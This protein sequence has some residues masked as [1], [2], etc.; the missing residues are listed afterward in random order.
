MK[1]DS[2]ISVVIAG[3][4]FCGLMTLVNLIKKSS[5]KI[6][7]TLINKGYPL[8]RGVAFHSY[9]E[10]HL[11]NV[12]ARNMSAFADQPEH[13]VEWC[14]SYNEVGTHADDIPT[15][16]FPR[17]LY[18]KYLLDIFNSSISDLDP[19]IKVNLVDD[20]MS[21]IEK[22]EESFIVYTSQGK[23]IQADK[24]VLATG[25]CE[26]GPPVLNNPEFIKSKKYFSNPWSEQAVL[27][28]KNND[29]VLIIGSGLT[30][31][32]VII[33][34]R[35][36]DFTGKI[37][38]LS[39]HGFNILPHRKSTPQRY[40]L[41]EL[42][43]PYT[44]ENLFRLFYKH[45]RQARK[46]GQS[47]ETVVDAIRAKTQE[48]WQNISHDDK[49]KF[50]THLRH[51]WG[52]ARHRLPSKIHSQ[53]QQMIQDKKLEIIAGRIKNINDC[54]NGIEVIAQRRK[55]QSELVI[56][57]ARIINCTGPQTDIRKQNS[58][59]YNS[60]LKKGMIRPDEMNLGID[61]NSE[62]QV[63]EANNNT[64]ESIYA[65]GSLL[66]GKLWESTA[67]PELRSQASRLA[68]AL[69][70]VSAIEL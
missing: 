36:K 8:A 64:C 37:I 9:S 39:P 46:H 56:K 25:N 3:G 15:T 17:N 26:P 27:N 45:I 31:A 30:M 32:D 22:N 16:Y 62:F 28:L 12:E 2:G 67:V 54:E 55:D 19:N 47:G 29:D 59:L 38:S 7:I 18:G 61:A 1:S 51:I 53:I 44:L 10:L 33:G 66:K 57:V 4:G 43:P 5:H 34:L 13:F 49:K 35:E 52:V 42:N 68:D 24:I 58:A 20:E 48:I 65:I 69:V 11:L 60:L 14:R 21:D 23:K 70:K 6:N 63:I 50:M 41:D 40:I